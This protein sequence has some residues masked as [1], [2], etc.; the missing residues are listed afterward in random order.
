MFKN[1]GKKVYGIAKVMFW[2][3]SAVFVTLDIVAAVFM[4]VIIY[5][6][7]QLFN[8]MSNSLLNPSY[9]LFGFG[10]R[11]TNTAQIDSAPYIFLVWL[12]AVV[13]GVLIVMIL[14]WCTLLIITY[15]DTNIEVK[16]IR[17]KMENQSM[18]YGSQSWDST[19]AQPQN[20]W[21]M[22]TTPISQP[23]QVYQSAPAYQQTYRP[24]PV[25]K[26]VYQDAPEKKIVEEAPSFTPPTYSEVDQNYMPHQIESTE[27]IPSA[28]QDTKQLNSKEDILSKYGPRGDIYK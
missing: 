27:D 23:T 18:E 15:A 6:M 1:P 17:E 9:S 8:S 19:N 10:S 4:S 11:S 24:E 25:Y 28:N 26:P 2:M 12:F 5:S 3:F 7:T 14:Y 22:N 13:F 16:N 20:T 21:D